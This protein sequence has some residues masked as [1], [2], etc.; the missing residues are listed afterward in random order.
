MGLLGFSGVLSGL[1][2]EH[3]PHSNFQA[4]K[5]HASTALNFT[6]GFRVEHSDDCTSPGDK[7]SLLALYEH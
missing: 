2:P 7:K 1:V 4:C 6:L 3:T 5:V